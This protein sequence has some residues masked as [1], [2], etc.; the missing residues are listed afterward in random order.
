MSADED[1]FW[2]YAEALLERPGF[3]R[4]TM[5]R[6]PC[7]RLDEKFFASDDRRTGDLLVK[8]PAPRVHLLVEAGESAPVRPGR[9]PVPR[10]GRDWAGQRRNLA[11]A[12]R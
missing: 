11:E 5:L 12:S 8:Q 2:D 1:P 7:R 9:A 4:S 3:T 6:L 10:V